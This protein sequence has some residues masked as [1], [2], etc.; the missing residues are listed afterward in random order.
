MNKKQALA[1]MYDFYNLHILRG[2]NDDINYYKKQI[3]L[4]NS[5]NIL[6][7]GA[8]TGRVAIPLSEVSDVVALDKDKERLNVLL[9]KKSNI[10]TV[11]CDI[12][13][14]KSSKKYD[15]VIFPYSTIQFL[16]NKENIDQI[17][18]VIRSIILSDS[19][20]LFDISEN[21]NNK[22]EVNEKLLF[23]DYSTEVHD[24]IKVFYTAIR[25]D[26]YIEF[27]VSYKLLENNILLLEDEFYYYYDKD[28]FCN[29]FEKENF[30]TVKIDNGYGNDILTHKYIY[31]V[32]PKK[33]IRK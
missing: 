30:Q 25:K 9:Q 22:P 5:K 24:Y 28:F 10:K 4:Y 31:H 8:G 33:L 15:M 3:K 20:V 26:D 21:F 7:V 18:G 12:K 19:I 16:E 23:E 17:L 32:K 2:Q 6:I 11:C 29:A 13:D 14:F 27:R 1:Y